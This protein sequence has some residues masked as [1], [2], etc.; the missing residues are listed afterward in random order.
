M[1]AVQCHPKE[2]RGGSTFM[3]VI[4]GGQSVFARG[5]ERAE[6]RDSLPFS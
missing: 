4:S 3:Q 1:S 2:L 6:T 5:D